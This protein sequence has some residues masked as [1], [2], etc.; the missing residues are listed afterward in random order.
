[1]NLFRLIF[2]DYY[3]GSD[4]HAWHAAPL[5]QDVSEVISEYDASVVHKPEL[6]AFES[7]I[8]HLIGNI[9]HVPYWPDW[10]QPGT[11]DTESR[12]NYASA[13]DT[14]VSG[15]RLK[16]EKNKHDLWFEYTDGN[17][18]TGV[19]SSLLNELKREDSQVYSRRAHMKDRRAIIAFRVTYSSGND[20]A[21]TDAHLTCLIDLDSGRTT[22]PL[23]EN[24]DIDMAG[25]ANEQWLVYGVNHTS[26]YNFTNRNILT[27]TARAGTSDFLYIYGDSG[28]T[29][30]YRSN[31]FDGASLK[32][33]LQLKLIDTG[34]D[35][36]EF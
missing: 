30:E 8:S 21:I 13:S 27:K 29:E 36:K 17:G 6:Q 28:T 11:G 7:R 22:S 9:D 3:I 25:R 14:P 15:L 2:D 12:E 33:N 18:N 31:L 26:S 32:E 16:G 10:E 5:T 1:M 20:S 4:L 35:V 34:N 24:I 19:R 23:P